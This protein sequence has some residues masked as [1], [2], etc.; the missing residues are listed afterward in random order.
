MA[1]IAGDVH[2]IIRASHVNAA[3]LSF[4]PQTVCSRSAVVARH[5][6]TTVAQQV[7]RVLL[8]RPS[9]VV[10]QSG[11]RNVAGVRRGRLRVVVQTPPRDVQEELVHQ[12]RV[13]SRWWLCRQRAAEEWKNRQVAVRGYGKRHGGGSRRQVGEGRQ[14]SRHG[15]CGV[16]NQHFI[17]SFIA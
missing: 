7:C 10:G 3:V 5:H 1:N 16:C 12:A 15:R 13:G 9:P 2:V 4:C 6:V 8:T 11:G 17:F 14:A